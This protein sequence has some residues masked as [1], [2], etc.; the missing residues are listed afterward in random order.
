MPVA[1]SHWL[2]WIR[3][4]LARSS[5]P[6]PVGS[7]TRAPPADTFKVVRTPVRASGGTV[8]E[9]SIM[10]DNMLRQMLTSTYLK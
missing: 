1:D 6:E 10:L 8:E 2:K 5:T 4:R 7:L 3:H 9:L